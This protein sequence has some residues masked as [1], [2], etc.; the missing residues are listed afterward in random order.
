MNI[1]TRQVPLPLQKLQAVI[2]RLQP[3]FQNYAALCYEERNRLRG[4]EGEKEIDYYLNLLANRCTILQDVYLKVN[5]KSFQLDSV[6]ATRRACYLIESKNYS[7]RVLLDTVLKQCILSNGK[8]ET[9]VNY[10]ITQAE[11]HKIQFENFLAKH[12][13]PD[14]PVYFFV[15]LSDPGTIIE[16]KGDDQEIVNKVTHG[17]QLPKMILDIDSKLEDRFQDYKLGKTI[18]RECGEFDFDIL[19]KY[20][21]KTTD[22]MPGVQC[23]KCGHIGMAR[24]YAYWECQSCK[25]RSKNAHV[26][27]VSDYLLLINPYIT[28]KECRRFLRITSKSL[29]TRILKECNLIYQKQHKRWYQHPSHTI[30]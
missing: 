1:R 5:G 13:L 18:L 3:G 30:T 10:P 28:N 6:L 12:N 20:G 21:V 17:E 26:K 29:A 24:T 8:V 14:V 19:N 4:F 23:P 16:V 27:A 7:K 11:N 9:G 15:A 2:P 25:C 22:I